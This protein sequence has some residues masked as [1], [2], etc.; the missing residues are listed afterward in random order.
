MN[1][2]AKPA[3]R[4]LKAGAT[5]T[6]QGT[7]G[8]EMFLLLNGVLSV[9]VD[10]EPLADVGPGAIVGE[11]AVLEGGLRTSTLR[12]LTKA[13]VAVARADQI[14]R[15]ALVEVSSGHRRETTT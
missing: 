12:A 3:I 11:R 14:D 7:R 5:L 9:E 10:G 13:K 4:G 8:D 1:S 2:G 15:E 6:E